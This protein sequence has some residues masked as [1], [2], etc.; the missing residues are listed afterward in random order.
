MNLM[1][2]YVENISEKEILVNKILKHEINK[3]SIVKNR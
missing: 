3:K 1:S 2:Q